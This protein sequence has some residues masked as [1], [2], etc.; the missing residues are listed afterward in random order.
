MRSD[1][2]HHRRGNYWLLMW[3]RML[4]WGQPD[5]KSDD[6]QQK[7]AEPRP[8]R[9]LR[10]STSTK[11]GARLAIAGGDSPAPVPPDQPGARR[12]GSCSVRHLTIPRQIFRPTGFGYLLASFHPRIEESFCR[13][14]FRARNN[15]VRTELS[16][17]LRT[18]L[19]SAF[20][21]S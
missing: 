14:R 21:N 12:R 6:Q 5:G 2:K 20:V 19:I 13:R 7:G 15:R 16:G 11:I 1:S 9:S 17:M 10:M 3:R 4:A 18:L 8:Q